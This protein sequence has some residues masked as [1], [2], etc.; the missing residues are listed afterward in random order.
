TRRKQVVFIESI[1]KDEELVRRNI[2]AMKESSPEFEDKTEEETVR[3]FRS[4][5]ERY[6]RIYQ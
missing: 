3:E 2:V 4:R 6:E 5:I 1:C